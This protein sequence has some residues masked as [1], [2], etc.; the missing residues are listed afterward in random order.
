MFRDQFRGGLLPYPGHTRKIV[1]IVATQRGV[2]NVLGRGDS[3]FLLHIGLIGHNDVTDPPTG[4]DDTNR[5][6]DQL[7]GVAVT[8]DDQDLPTVLNGVAGERRDDVI[9]FETLHSKLADL[10]RLQYL[11]HQRKLTLEVV[12]R[13]FPLRLVFRVSLCAEGLPRDVPRHR[14]SV[15]VVVLQ[16]TDKHPR[17]S[18]H[19]VGDLPGLG[20]EVFRKGVKGAVG[21]RVAVDQGEGR[22]TGDATTSSLKPFRAG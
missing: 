18:E 15:R 5:A 13:R 19:G 11:I 4:V 7:E 2:L 16:Q 20:G 12:R 1:G 21:D 17:E 3:V 14:D 9:S 8:G 10:Q 22:H 6:S